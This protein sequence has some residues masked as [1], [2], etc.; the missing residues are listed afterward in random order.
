MEPEVQ[1][2]SMHIAHEKEQIGSV[3]I[4]DKVVA[5][6]ARMALDEVDGVSLKNPN[7]FKL[8]V[9]NGET[10]INMSLIVEFGYSIPQVVAVVQERV[11]AVIESMTGFKVSQINIRIDDIVNNK[12]SEGFV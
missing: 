3:T 4:A 11:S 10:I 5:N 7:R 1:S 8:E 2:V 12:K 9:V 6:I